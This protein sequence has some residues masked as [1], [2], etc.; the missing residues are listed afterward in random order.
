[1]VG[2]VGFS[3]SNFQNLLFYCNKY[4]HEVNARRQDEERTEKNVLKHFSIFVP[5]LNFFSFFFLLGEKKVK[6]SKNTLTNPTRLFFFLSL[7]QENICPNKKNFS[8]NIFCFFF[9]NTEFFFSSKPN[10]PKKPVM[11]RLVLFLLTIS[12]CSGYFI[13]SSSQYV[14]GIYMIEN[15]AQFTND[16]MWT[17][18]TSNGN[19]TYYREPDPSVEGE[20][21][22]HDNKVFLRNGTLLWKIEF[23]VNKVNNNR[24]VQR[25]SKYVVQPSLTDIIFYNI[26]NG[27]I[28]KNIS[29]GPI[30][31]FYLFGDDYLFYHINDKW[32][33]I[34]LEGFFMWHLPGSYDDYISISR[35][36]KLLYH[37][38]NFGMNIYAIESGQLIVSNISCY[39]LYNYV[40]YKIDGTT[41][42]ATDLY[43]QQQLFLLTF[44]EKPTII[45]GNETIFVTHGQQSDIIDRNTGNTLWTS[46]YPPIN[47]FSDKNNTY[48]LLSNNKNDLQVNYI[49][50]LTGNIMYSFSYDSI[51]KYNLYDI[52]FS[53]Y[54]N[55]FAETY[56]NDR[57]LY[58]F[59][60]SCSSGGSFPTCRASSKINPGIIIGIVFGT[61]VFLFL[62]M[63]LI[64][65][66]NWRHYPLHNKI[67][68]Q[69][70]LIFYIYPNPEHAFFKEVSD[71]LQ[72][73]NIQDIEQ[74]NE[75]AGYVS[76]NSG[77]DQKFNNLLISIK[78]H[79]SCFCFYSEGQ[80]SSKQNIIIQNI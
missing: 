32:N 53:R 18:D 26:S 51:Y 58:A 46:V 12:T 48:Y 59:S 60:S 70:W 42:S 8:E 5:Q 34:Q 25:N 40:C 65:E 57:V 11:F 22:I 78:K 30:D 79:V 1:M 16:L 61:I 62:L 13:E 14:D 73:A 64:T 66:W 4:F 80:I 72:A 67:R 52:F 68:R 3:S 54:G 49:E 19:L 9:V 28:V 47:V 7:V 44:H 17:Y 63:I 69:I 31:A 41:L 74:Q 43:H 55:L 39:T 71:L 56:P 23:I 24:D 45:V 36:R 15:G 27:D 35:N 37:G 20:Y 2:G 50:E 38:T 76:L 10:I 21:I 29:S 6:T 33:I 77:D 75:N